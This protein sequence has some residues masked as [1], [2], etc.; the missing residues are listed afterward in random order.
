MKKMTQI[1]VNS[2][3]FNFA[4]NFTFFRKCWYG[5]FLRCIFYAPVVRSSACQRFVQRL[6]CEKL[7]AGLNFSTVGDRPKL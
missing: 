6:N 4:F 3:V 1:N 7:A 2:F 5:L